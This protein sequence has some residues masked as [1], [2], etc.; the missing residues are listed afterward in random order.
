MGTVIPLR[1]SLDLYLVILF[2]SAEN[3]V[4]DKYVVAKNSNISTLNQ[5]T[6]QEP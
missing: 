3:A 6:Y 1:F 4:S 2:I 5:N